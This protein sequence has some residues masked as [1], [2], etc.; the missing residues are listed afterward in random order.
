MKKVSLEKR[1]MAYIHYMRNTK[2]KHS[3]GRIASSQI[4]SRNMARRVFM[5]LQIMG[6]I[7]I[8]KYSYRQNTSA[9]RW[10]LFAGDTDCYGPKECFN[11]Y[12]DITDNALSRAREK[13][14]K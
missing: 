2:G 1:A 8:E 6:A 5:R 7:T 13:F 11:A 12:L 14:Q 9:Y 4:I 3:I 10:T